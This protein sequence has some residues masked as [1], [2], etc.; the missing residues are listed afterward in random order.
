MPSPDIPSPFARGTER[1]EWNALIEPLHVPAKYRKCIAC[2]L[3]QHG[4]CSP[5]HF[6]ELLAL[7]RSP[8]G[9][10]REFPGFTD[11]DLPEYFRGVHD[12]VEYLLELPAL[13]PDAPPE[14]FYG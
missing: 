6:K 7:H 1:A 4:V 3:H 2:I 8:D 13:F 5:A 9:M 12:K 11:D 14:N 10:Q